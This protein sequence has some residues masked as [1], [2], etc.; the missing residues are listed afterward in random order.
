METEI[1]S[2]LLET[3]YNRVNHVAIAKYGSEPN[4][5]KLCGEYF[6][7]VYSKSCYGEYYEDSEYVYP[8]EL[9]IELDVL[10]EERK[11]KEKKERQERRIQ[12]EKERIERE[13]IDKKIRERKYL[14]L[15]KEFE[16]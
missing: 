14:E 1:T 16:K 10:I 5:I 6:E 9:T 11:I 13:N 4:E 2:E 15:K 3:I 7:V 8:A 12:Q